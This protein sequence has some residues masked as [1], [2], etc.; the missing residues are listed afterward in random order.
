[1]GNPFLETILV[2]RTWAIHFWRLSSENDMGNPFLETILVSTTWAIH[3][4]RL[5]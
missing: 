1:M 3:F 4:W 5:F 2:S